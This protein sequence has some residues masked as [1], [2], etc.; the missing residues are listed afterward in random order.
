MFLGRL[1]GFDHV[2]PEPFP[3]G[4]QDGPALY[5]GHAQNRRIRTCHQPFQTGIAVH[6]D[7]CTQTGIAVHKDVCT[8]TGIAVHNDACTQTG[9]FT[10]EEGFIQKRT[11]KSSLLLGGQN[12]F[13][14]PALAMYCSP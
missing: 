7:V 6:K 13:N 5:A 10:A 3:A 2:G 8:Q 12:L 14:M 9:L 11:Q 1:P 4:S